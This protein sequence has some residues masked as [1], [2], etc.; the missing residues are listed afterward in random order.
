MDRFRH[1][2]RDPYENKE[3]VVKSCV[4]YHRSQ[5]FI[6]K[7][8]G[9]LR[10]RGTFKT[11]PTG[12]LQDVVDTFEDAEPVFQGLV[13]LVPSGVYDLVCWL[14]EYIPSL[15]HA[16]TLA[17]EAVSAIWGQKCSK[18]SGFIRKEYLVISAE[19]IN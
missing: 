9:P 15:L 3:M 19:H 8:S 12:D 14:T 2:S 18:I 1:P 17:F 5:F 4:F 7:P 10:S 11:K 13:Q 6:T 16:T